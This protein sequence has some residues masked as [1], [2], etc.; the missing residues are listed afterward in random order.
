[1]TLSDGQKVLVQARFDRWINRAWIVE[2][3]GGPDAL[4]AI[5]RREIEID[6]T[7]LQAAN[8]AGLDTWRPGNHARLLHHEPGLFGEIVVTEDSYNIRSMRFGV[9]GARQSLMDIDA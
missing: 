7:S 6:P 8:E 3:L 4:M 2:S 1:M 9:N 5:I